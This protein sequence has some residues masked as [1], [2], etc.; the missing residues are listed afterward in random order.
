[1]AVAVA[2]RHRRRARRST[3]TRIVSIG[4]SQERAQVAGTAGRQPISTA[5]SPPPYSMALTMPSAPPEMLLPD[6]IQQN[7]STPQSQYPRY[8]DSTQFAGGNLQ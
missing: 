1:M 5:E 7:I 6:Q 8:V 4:G 3:N 2:V